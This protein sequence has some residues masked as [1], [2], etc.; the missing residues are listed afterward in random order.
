MD[1]KR[2]HTPIQ[3]LTNEET[4][5]IHREVPASDL[6][7]CSFCILRYTSLLRRNIIFLNNLQERRKK[8]MNPICFISIVLL[9]FAVIYFLFYIGTQTKINMAADTIVYKN[10]TIFKG[11]GTGNK[12]VVDCDDI[13]KIILMTTGGNETSPLDHP[14][15]ARLHY[16]N[17]M[18][19]CFKFYV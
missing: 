14:W 19:I 5:L 6:R 13:S 16:K 17:G 15:L 2:I 10:V 1:Y 12:L 7:V 3:D 8:C 18:T 11:D 9:I 4:P